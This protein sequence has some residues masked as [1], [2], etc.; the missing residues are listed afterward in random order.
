MF[1]NYELILLYNNCRQHLSYLK[2]ILSFYTKRWVTNAT[3]KCMILEFFSL[4]L[5]HLFNMY[6]P[7][8][9]PYFSIIVIIS[10][11]KYVKPYDW[12]L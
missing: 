12:D 9:K 10:I 5:I 4:I 1:S 7:Q 6:F 2:I 11:I 8:L 3:K